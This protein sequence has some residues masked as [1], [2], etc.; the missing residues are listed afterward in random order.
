[1]SKWTRR[2]RGE[3][4]R[5]ERIGNV[6]I[7]LVSG[8]VSCAVVEADAETRLRYLE[9]HYTL[10]PKGVETWSAA[11]LEREIAVARAT[12]HRKDWERTLL[13]L[14][15]HQSEL[16]CD[17]LRQ[18][19]PQVP[20][21]LHGFHQLALGEALGWLGYDYVT[22]EEGRGKAVPAGEDWSSPAN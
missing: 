14:A 19:E 3:K 8:R 12:G 18:V 7:D 9:L 10:V 13:R 16:A 5:K 15:H 4:R 20:V 17:L 1:M 11:R 21:E 2:G 6:L 22:D